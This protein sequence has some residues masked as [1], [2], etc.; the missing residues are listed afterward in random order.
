M[1]SNHL[2]L[3]AEKPHDLYD[4]SDE[5]YYWNGEDAAADDEDYD[6][7]DDKG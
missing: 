6:F 3:Q 7:V 1:V 4:S 5:G 2:I